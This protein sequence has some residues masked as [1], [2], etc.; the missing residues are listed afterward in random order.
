MAS[1]Y[2]AA[3][4]SHH[5][6]TLKKLLLPSLWSLGREVLLNLVSNCPNLVQLAVSLEDGSFEVIRACVRAGPKLEA[7]RFLLPP[8][9]RSLMAQQG[10]AGIKMHEEVLMIECRKE[11]Y[12][13]VRWLGLGDQTFEICGIKT[14]PDGPGYRRDIRYVRPDDPRLKQVE[15]FGLDSLEI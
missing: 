3:I 10:E 15:I 7:L 9:S 11:E 1:D 8:G 13:T 12:K 2:I 6:S 4:V 14:M 5:S